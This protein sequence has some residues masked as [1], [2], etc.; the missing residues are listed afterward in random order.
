MKEPANFP[1]NK[2]QILMSDRFYCAPLPV[3]ETARLE[4]A[5]ARH[6]SRVLR[7]SAGDVIELF[8]GQ[9]TSATAEIL[10]AHKNDV[11][12][13]LLQTSSTAPPENQVILAT[14][15]PKGDRFRWLVEKAVELDVDR[16]IPLLTKRSVVKPGRGKQDKMEQAVI[17]ACKQCRRNWLMTIEDPKPWTAFLEDDLKTADA[18]LLAHPRGKLLRDAFPAPA[19]SKLLL[20]VGPEGGWTAEEVAEAEDAGAVRVSLGT[21]ILRIE[22]AAIALASYAQ[23][24]RGTSPF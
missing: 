4:G 24:Q 19:F 11:E 12:L 7:K 15:V 8:D 20:I 23:F 6:L 17:E 9:G 21:N 5:E 16:L 22:T 18:A 13:K 3:G 2:S 10:A 14:A 1:A